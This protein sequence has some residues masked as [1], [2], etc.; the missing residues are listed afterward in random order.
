MNSLFSFPLQD[1]YWHFLEILWLFIFLF[2]YSSSSVSGFYFLGSLVSRF[3]SL[4]PISTGLCLR[5]RESLESIRLTSCLVNQVS[6]NQLMADPKDMKRISSKRNNILKQ[7]WLS[8]S[9]TSTL[10]ERKEKQA[11]DK[12]WISKLLFITNCCCWMLDFSSSRVSLVSRLV[13]IGH[14]FS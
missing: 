14:V 7:V 13:W 1:F 5:P 9:T 8:S 10:Q 11:R 3:H 6:E 2:L 4:L 12:P